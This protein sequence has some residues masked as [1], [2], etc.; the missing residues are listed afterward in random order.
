M[1]V[2]VSGCDPASAEHL[3]GLAFVALDALGSPDL[4]L[5]VQVVDDHE[6]WIGWSN[7]QGVKVVAALLE[8][9]E[10]LAYTM[11]EE[12]A[13][14][15]LTVQFPTVRFGDLLHEL[16]AANFVS[17]HCRVRWDPRDDDLGVDYHLGSALGS[18][19]AGGDAALGAIASLVP[20]ERR[21][22]AVGLLALL[23][24]IRDPRELARALAELPA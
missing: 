11:A 16:F 21:E 24:G 17:R 12:V 3:T 18:A 2:T 15:W 23:G 14:H 8:D 10:E 5:R 13:H 6:E 22:Y 9:L 19:L 1:R 4:P 7:R 20:L